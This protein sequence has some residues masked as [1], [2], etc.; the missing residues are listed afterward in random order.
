MYAQCLF[1]GDF[2]STNLYCNINTWARNVGLKYN[3]YFYK[4]NAGVS[5]CS[6]LPHSFYRNV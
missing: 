6:K 2:F 4:M 5:I 3:R 1:T